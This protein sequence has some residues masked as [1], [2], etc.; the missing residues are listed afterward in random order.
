MVIVE[1]EEVTRR[2]IL[3]MDIHCVGGLIDQ[4]RV[5]VIFDEI[6]ILLRD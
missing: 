6:K 2:N 1:V 3:I 4:T 5:L